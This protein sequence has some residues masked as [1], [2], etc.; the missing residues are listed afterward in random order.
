MSSQIQNQNPYQQLASLGATILFDTTLPATKAIVISSDVLNSIL[1][2]KLKLS[3]V[4]GM[5]ESLNVTIIDNDELLEL[6]AAQRLLDAL[7]DAGVDNWQGYC[8]AY[9]A[10]VE[11]EAML[12]D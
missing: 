6:R 3:L 12:Y 8:D 2:I 11:A 9:S 7:E 5:A 4:Q 10:F 1:L